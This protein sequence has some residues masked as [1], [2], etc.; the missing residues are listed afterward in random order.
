MSLRT[1]KHAVTLEELNR[2]LTSRGLKPLPDDYSGP[3]LEDFQ[4]PLNQ[5][6]VD[7]VNGD[8]DVFGSTP[9]AMI[10]EKPK[11]P[12]QPSQP[13]WKWSW[14]PQGGLLIWEV[15]DKYGQPH[16]IEVTGPDFYKLAQ[17]RVYEIYDYQPYAENPKYWQIAGSEWEILVWEDRASLEWQEAAVEDVQ[18]W[19]LKNTGKEAVEAYWQGEGGYYQTIQDGTEPDLD[20][21]IE[22]YFGVG[23]KELS[24]KQKTKLRRQ[25]Q[26]LFGSKPAPGT[27]VQPQTQTTD[28]AE[29]HLKNDEKW[30][31]EFEQQQSQ[32]T[33]IDLCPTCLGSG[34]DPTGHICLTCRGSGTSSDA[35][36]P[37]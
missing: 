10:E 17:G 19:L 14:D 29:F 5:Q 34:E 25:Y 26:N 16:H 36:E 20:K 37:F 7:P 30:L 22:A 24:F 21:M 32:G 13:K 8:P 3:G 6:Q 9:P 2:W 15:D 11:K 35:V 28:P 18:A 4:L 23:M 27:K 1:R 31:R 33:D 12:A